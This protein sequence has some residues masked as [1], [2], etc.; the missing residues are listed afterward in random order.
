VSL[1]Y[2]TQILT[3]P[4]KLWAL[5]TLGDDGMPISVAFLALSVLAAYEMHADEE[6]GPNA[7]Y[8]R[9]ALLLGIDLVA[10]HPRGFDLQDFEGLWPPGFSIDPLTGI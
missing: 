4:E 10:G 1:A 8:P 5:A 9:L 7:Y 3:E 6:A 2:R